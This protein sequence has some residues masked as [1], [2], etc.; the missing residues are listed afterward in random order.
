MGRLVY[1]ILFFFFCF[2][3]ALRSFSRF[4]RSGGCTPSEGTPS[5]TFFNGYMWPPPYYHVFAGLLLQGKSF[6][7]KRKHV[8]VK[9]KNSDDSSMTVIIL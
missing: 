6:L 7:R 2:H 5:C 8:G 4:L 3:S 1:Y 9:K